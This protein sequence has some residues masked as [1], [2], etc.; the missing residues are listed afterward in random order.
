MGLEVAILTVLEPAQ[1]VRPMIEKIKAG[2]F[3]TKYP[4]YWIHQKLE[5]SSF[6]L[7]NLDTRK[8]DNYLLLAFAAAA[9][10]PAMLAKK[11]KAIAIKPN[12]P[13]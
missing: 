2:F 4:H 8:S 9:F 12:N 6:W 11:V 3:I 1:D 13:V 7:L 10:A 5:K